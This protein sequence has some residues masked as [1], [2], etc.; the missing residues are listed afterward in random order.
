[1]LNNPN[2]R[3]LLG[4]VAFV[5]IAA[6][7]ASRIQT[8]GGTVRVQGISIPTQNGQWVA[9]DLFRPVSATAESPAPLVVVVP[10][11]QR[12]REAL[13]NT[14]IELSRRGIV[15]ISIDPYAQGRSSSSTSRMAA[16]TE[17]YGSF[18][19]I[20]YA[21]GS[22]NLNYVDKSRLAI[23]GHSA[24]G[25]AA[26]RGAN[27]FGRE[28]QRTGEPS[29]LHSVYMS[30]YVLT[31]RDEVLADVRSNIG[32]AYAL[33]DEGAYRNELGNGDMRFAPE[34]LRRMFDRFWRGDRARS[35][36]GAGLGLAIARG[37][38]EAQGGRIWAENR[39][40]GGGRVCFTLPAA[41]SRGLVSS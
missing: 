31:L 20:D 40:G 1:M 7:I 32:V 30:G 2:N 18:A 3:L 6:F 27:Y 16:T 36:D 26:I 21:A 5:I 10:G 37:L 22:E 25:N 28:A 15:A 13:A 35:A 29:K 9:A 8:A 24:G 11:F 41:A 39:Q 12:S 38:V 4:L 14:A 33:Y 17:G 23:T 34:A 19:V